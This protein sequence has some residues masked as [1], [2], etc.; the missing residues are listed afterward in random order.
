MNRI[1]RIQN[2]I[3]DYKTLDPYLKNLT[4]DSYNYYQKELMNQYLLVSKHPLPQ[5]Y[6]NSH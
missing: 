5:E 4:Q 6:L 1:Q 3:N 2:F